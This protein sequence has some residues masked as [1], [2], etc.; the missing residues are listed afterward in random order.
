MNVEVREFRVWDGRGL[1]KIKNTLA[2]SGEIDLALKV[3]DTRWRVHKERLD[4]GEADKVEHPVV[5]GE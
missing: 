1:R 2:V 4:N 5:D 3:A